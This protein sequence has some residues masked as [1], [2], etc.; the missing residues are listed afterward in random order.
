MHIVTGGAGFIGSAMVWKLNTLGVDDILVVDNLSES[1]KWKNLVNLRYTDYLHKSEF[2]DRVLNG[3]DFGRV[4]GVI[5]MGAC[6]ATT[7]LDADY[8]MDNNLR[9]SRTL[10]LWAE[11]LGARFINASSAATYG[12]GSLG[13]SDN[14]AG[15]TR[16]KPLNMYGYSKQLFDL[17]ALKAGRLE[18]L[19]S[20]KF[21][22]VYGPNEYHKGDMMSVVAKAHA[23]IGE[24]GSL[25]LFK[26]HHPDYADGGQL[27]D[28]ISVKD[29]LE[30]MA[31]L[32]EH[33]EAN[34]V[35]NIGT[36]QARSFED[37]GRA[38]FTAMGRTPDIE[39]VDMPEAIRGKYQYYT[40]AE[41]RK[42][43]AVGYDREFLSLEDG[44]ADYVRN[45]LDKGDPYLDSNA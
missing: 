23:Q 28:F 1:D 18:T 31:W 7:E 9:Y 25:R 16:F 32:L 11:G 33:P 12:D 4:E 6:S 3:E 14:H 39:F 22:N 35:F 34:G 26:S 15:L 45:H 42:L 43:R 20:L 21:F 41:M 24:R 30:V 8:L 17:W 29:C 27:R 2:M 19:A 5:H 40:Q 37:L 10:A 13:F 38:V 36:G 44:V